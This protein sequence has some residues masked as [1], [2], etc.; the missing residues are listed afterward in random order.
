MSER[1]FFSDEPSDDELDA[2]LDGPAPNDAASSDEDLPEDSD[3]EEYVSEASEEEGE[4]FEDEGED[5]GEGEEESEDEG[6]ASPLED[7]DG[8]LGELDDDER[9]VVENLVAQASESEQRQARLQDVSQIALFE[10]RKRDLQI[11]EL[12]VRARIATLAA[13]DPERFVE[14]QKRLQWATMQ[15]QQQMQSPEAQALEQ[16]R[17]GLRRFI[18][19]N[20]EREEREKTLTHVRN[21]GS[22]RLADGSHIRFEKLNA[23]E[24][25]Y[26][27]SAQTPDE[28]DRALI[29]IRNARQAS[30]ERARAAQ[31]QQRT[32]SGR[33][34]TGVRS[35]GSGKRSDNYDNYS[36]DQLD[37]YLEDTA[38]G[39][40]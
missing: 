22:W 8:W 38:L 15:R 4:D 29:N 2:V 33:D 37:Q 32:S 40:R 24:D 35:T 12:E 9:E 7:F 10:I 1:D 17:D 23:L 5:R 21:G 28:F 14:F 19:N 11:Q 18:V 34:R 36:L 16:A 3:A 31:R 30:T 20:S 25:Q 6:Y 26:L 39:V 27:S 13:E